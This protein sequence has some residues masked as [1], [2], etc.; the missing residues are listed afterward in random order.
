M[1]FDSHIFMQVL[2]QQGGIWVH[3]VHVERGAGDLA[4]SYGVVHTFIR[5]VILKTAMD[6]DWVH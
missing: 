1:L 4:H 5:I 2:S 3:N 6:M